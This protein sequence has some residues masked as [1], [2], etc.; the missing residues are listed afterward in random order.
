MI[1]IPQITRLQ[2][3]GDLTE[4]FTVTVFTLTIV[5]VGV[6]LS[7]SIFSKSCN[8]VL[9]A[10]RVIIPQTTLTQ[11]SEHLVVEP[12][13]FIISILAIEVVVVL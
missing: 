2:D 4:F 6:C 1:I 12:L 11:D 8:A 3:T 9:N 7:F 10:F 5:F 13:S